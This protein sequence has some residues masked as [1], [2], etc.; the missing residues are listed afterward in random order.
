MADMY[1]ACHFWHP[2]SPLI[3]T[4]SAVKATDCKI[5]VVGDISCD[6]GGPVASTIRSS[7]IDE[8]LFGFDPITMSETSYKD[9]SSITCMAV[10]NLPCELPL[11]SSEDFGKNDFKN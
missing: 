6:V 7:T 3:L 4:E 8:P 5:R 1:I 9:E 10:D 2:K 11:D